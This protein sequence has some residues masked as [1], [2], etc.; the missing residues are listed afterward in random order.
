[1][2]RE[3]WD[4]YYKFTI[5]RNPFDRIVSKYYYAKRNAK[6]DQS[7]E[8]YLNTEV[9]RKL[10]RGTWDRY[11]INGRVAVDRVCR[12]ENLQQE[13]EEVRLHVGIPEPLELPH[14]KGAHRADKGSYRDLFGETPPQWVYEV[15]REELDTF[16]YTY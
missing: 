11:T 10:R 16:G 14:A 5:T 9:P 8:E 6:T 2:G 1:M 7:F 3:L 13:L 15:F 4:S 12:Y